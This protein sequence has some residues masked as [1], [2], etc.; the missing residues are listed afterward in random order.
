MTGETKQGIPGKGGARIQRDRIRQVAPERIRRAIAAGNVPA[1]CA[2]LILVAVELLVVI[3]DLCYLAREPRRFADAGRPYLARA[4]AAR[5]GR[6]PVWC[7]RHVGR[8]LRLLVAAD[9]IVCRR[10]WM[11]SSLRSLSPSLID[12]LAKLA[13]KGWKPPKDKP[14][15]KPPPPQPFTASTEPVGDMAGQ[16][17]QARTIRDRLKRGPP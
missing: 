7:V 12:D 1:D 13:R 8:M 14:G 15:P 10:R 9:L 2:A 5:S 16:A 4:L 17:D 6:E 11:M 3:A